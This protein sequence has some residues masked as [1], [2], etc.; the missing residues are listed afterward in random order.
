MLKKFFTVLLGSMAA[1]WLSVILFT[2]LFFVMLGSLAAGIFAE[3]GAPGVVKENTVLVIDL[4][5]DIAEREAAGSLKS[6]I[7]YDEG[8]NGTLAEYIAAID[9]ARSDDRIKGILIKC[10][11]ATLGTASREELIEALHRF[12]DRKFIIAY[13]DSYSQGD[14]YVA[15]AANELYLNPVGNLDL[16]G[17]A[18]QTPFFTGLLDKIGV[19]MQIVKVG[20]FKSAV[21]PFILKSASEPSIQQTQTY[22]NGLWDEVTGYISERRS[23]STDTIKAYAADIASMYAPETLIADSLVDRLAYY[24]EV[25]EILKKRAG[26]KADDELRTV[27]PADYLASEN[28]NTA[29]KKHIAVYYATGDIVDNGSEGIS[30]SEVVPDIIALADDENVAG[31]IL[32]V[33]SGG[34][35]A[36]ASEQIWEAI[37]Y[38]KSKNKPVYASMSDVAASG[39]YYIS[40]GADRIYAD[41]TTLT[42]SIGIFGMIPCLEGLVTD[43]LGVTFTT[44]QTNRNADFINVMAPMPTEQA[45]AMQRM[46][47]RGYETFVGRVAAGRGL[48]VDS[49]K[50]IGEGRVWYGRD[51]LRIG[52]VDTLASLHSA[53]TDMAAAL[54]LDANDI[55]DYPEV[56]YPMF[57][58]LL[59]MMQADAKIESSI[60]SAITTQGVNLNREGRR[61]VARLSQILAQLQSGANIQARMEDIE[62]Q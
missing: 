47:E 8:V 52:L 59:R 50:V 41:A 40:C 37:E 19:K 48:S 2:I 14:Y 43:K 39:G 18:A 46:V 44:V 57:V 25:V 11:G 51:A 3:S 23:I 49:V 58:K 22:I 5:G 38:F 10:G 17:I 7:L 33:N 34:G 36:F 53:K 30:A 29:D 54:H 21:E 24:R 6:E 13:A 55:I 31:L 32:R 56:E 35:S 42:G 26:L 9:A 1:I 12:G 45:N 60:I 27:I 61:I 15:C 62:I 20:K 4:T 16:H 28:S